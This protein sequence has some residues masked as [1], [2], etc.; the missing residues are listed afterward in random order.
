MHF[1]LIDI[2]AGLCGVAGCLYLFSSKAAASLSDLESAR[3]NALRQRLRRVC[4]AMTFALGVVLMGFN[5][6]IVQRSPL[7]FAAVLLSAMVLLLAVVVL[8][9]IDVRMTLRLGPRDETGDQP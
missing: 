3:Q 1:L 5:A 4:G 7:A 2:F 9:Y 8:A 6:A